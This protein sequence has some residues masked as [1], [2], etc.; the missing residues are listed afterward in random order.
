MFEPVEENPMIAWRGASRYVDP[1]F[2]PAFEMECEA[3]RGVVQ[4]YG[5]DNLQLMIPFCRSPE[6]GVQVKQILEDNQLG[7]DDGVPLFI[8]VELNQLVYVL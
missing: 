1:K 7:Q 8:M 5:L 4:E 2:S 6:E 3:L